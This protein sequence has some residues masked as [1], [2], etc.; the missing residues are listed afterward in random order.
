M[1]M[2]WAFLLGGQ[3]V[4]KRKKQRARKSNSYKLLLGTAF[5]N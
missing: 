4:K 5:C 3:Q 1:G 2:V